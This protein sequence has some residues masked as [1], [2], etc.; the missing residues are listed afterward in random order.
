MGVGQVFVFIIAALTFSL[1]LIF[2]YK[3]ITDFL[4]R[5][6]EVQFYQF[7]TH[8]ETSV[9][10]IY[11]EFGSM[12]IEQF[13]VPSQYT[14]ICFVDLDRPVNSELCVIDPLAC[15]A[16][17]TYQMRGGFE[18]GD[19]NVFLTPLTS[20]QVKVSKIKMDKNYLCVPIRNG[21]FSLVLEGKG[22]YTQLSAK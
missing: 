6:E 13:S 1:I 17:Q 7:K 21:L 18:N 10:Q 5:G 3:V 16:W 22:S 15:D 4:Q 20:I 19:Q 9:K 11:T 14:L 8:L 12:R 2:G